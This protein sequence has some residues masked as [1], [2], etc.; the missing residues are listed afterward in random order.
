MLT[1]FLVGREEKD[2]SSWF[3]CTLLV[4]SMKNVAG[5][6]IPYTSVFCSL[7]KVQMKSYGC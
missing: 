2:I 3:Q 7:M 4:M 1:L 5:L 6:V